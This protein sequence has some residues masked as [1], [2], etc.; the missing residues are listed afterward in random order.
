MNNDLLLKYTDQQKSVMLVQGRGEGW[1]VQKHM[2]NPMAASWFGT[3]EPRYCEVIFY[4]D[5]DGYSCETMDLYGEDALWPA[6]DL[7]SWYISADPVLHQKMKDWI[8]WEIR[9]GDMLRALHFLIQP[10][11]LDKV[12]LLAI[13]VGLIEEETEND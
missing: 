10:Q 5:D 7:I 8:G 1:R 11:A 3:E 2:I 6:I 4:K 12:F 9:T 13:E